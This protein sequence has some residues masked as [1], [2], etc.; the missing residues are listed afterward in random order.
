[1]DKSTV[2][3][4]AVG[5]IGLGLAT[6]G[7]GAIAGGVLGG[8]FGGGIGH[9]KRVG[10]NEDFLNNLKA[11][12]AMEEYVAQ[13]YGMNTL[14]ELLYANPDQ[15]ANA[16]DGNAINKIRDAWDDSPEKGL[17]KAFNG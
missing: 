12:P 16:D 14:Q 5:A 9:H 2:I 6:G 4:G 1:M 15:L 3:G 11:N 7:I 13:H 17:A 10:D 8:I